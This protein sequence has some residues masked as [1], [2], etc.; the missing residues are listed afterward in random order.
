M[1]MEDAK[2]LLDQLSEEIR[3]TLAQGLVLR[4][5]ELK[6]LHKKLEGAKF[7]TVEVDAEM[8]LLEGTKEEKGLMAIMGAEEKEE[9]PDTDQATLPMEGETDYRTWNMTTD[10][11]RELVSDIAAD[12]SPA[13]AVIIMNNLE[14]G[15]KKRDGGPRK[16][17][18]DVIRAARAPL[19]KKVPHMKV[20]N[21]DG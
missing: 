1:L 17:V 8:K 9:K 6:G 10:Q 11:V 2:L 12:E 13:A 7:S 14:D 4:L 18:L 5:K 21:G 3:L 20:V 15:E 16:S 19:A